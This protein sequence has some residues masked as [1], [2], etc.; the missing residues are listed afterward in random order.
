MLYTNN[1]QS[2]VILA[3]QTYQHAAN[4]MMTVRKEKNFML[5]GKLKCCRNAEG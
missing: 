5:T 1:Q 3:R 2:Q 4:V